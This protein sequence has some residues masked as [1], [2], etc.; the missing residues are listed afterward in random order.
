MGEAVRQPLHVGYSQTRDGAR[1]PVAQNFCR[2]QHI[3]A[4]KR[5][6]DLQKQS[7]TRTEELVVNARGRQFAAWGYRNS[8]EQARQIIDPFE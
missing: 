2:N 8:T 4:L 5:S 3:F 6:D 7:F 1:H